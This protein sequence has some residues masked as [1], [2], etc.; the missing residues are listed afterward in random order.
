MGVAT[1]S[2]AVVPACPVQYRC[3]DRL[4]ADGELQGSA[5]IVWKP[6]DSASSHTPKVESAADS[7]QSEARCRLTGGNVFVHQLDQSDEPAFLSRSQGKLH[8]IFPSSDQ[9]PSPDFE[10]G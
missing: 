3:P 2:S 1:T 10:D 8:I 5:K 4:G 6:K 7:A 9:L